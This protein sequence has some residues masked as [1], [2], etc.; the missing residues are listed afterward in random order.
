[1]NR[2]CFNDPAEVWKLFTEDPVL[3]VY[4]AVCAYVLSNVHIF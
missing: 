1:M 3:E 4:T 2:E